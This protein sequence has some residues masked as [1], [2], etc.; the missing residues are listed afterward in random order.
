M[1]K[2]LFIGSFNNFQL[3]PKLRVSPSIRYSKLSKVDRDELFYE[4]YIF[5]G[6]MNFQFNRDISLR[7]ITEK[8]DFGNW[9]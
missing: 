5:R 1:G 7:V 4:G 8:N 6:N 3:S 2:S 9:C